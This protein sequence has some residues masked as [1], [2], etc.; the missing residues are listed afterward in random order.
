MLS[1]VPEEYVEDVRR[2]LCCLIC[3]SYPLPIQEVADN[4]AVTEGTPYYEVEN[5]LSEPPEILTICS[6][7]VST[8]SSRRTEYFTWGQVDIDELR[9]AHSLFK[10]TLYRIVLPQRNFPYLH[11]RYL[12]LTRLLQ[13]WS[14]VRL[15]GEDEDIYQDLRKNEV[16]HGLAFA[17]Y[18]ASFWFCHLQEARLDS[19]SPL[20][21]KCLRMTTDSARLCGMI[22]LRGIWSGND[23]R[24]EM[25]SLCELISVELLLAMYHLSIMRLC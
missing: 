7:L 1:C 24:N 21:C 18:A 23:E 22:R 5:Q 3:S 13:S 6:G 2:L 4:V 10:N 12:S 14:C 17:P 19:S 15:L 11:L 25:T 20:Y 9:L 8:I 16:L